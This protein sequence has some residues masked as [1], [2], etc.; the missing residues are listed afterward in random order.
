LGQPNNTPFFPKEGGDYWETAKATPLIT[1][2]E[3]LGHN[4]WLLGK[5]IYW[6][7]AGDALT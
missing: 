6:E 2:K 3:M 7:T 1:T 5:K 4:R